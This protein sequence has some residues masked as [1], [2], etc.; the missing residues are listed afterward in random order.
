MRQPKRY[1]LLTK[2]KQALGLAA[3]PPPGND[4]LAL[5]LSGGGARGVYQA[6]V[7]SFIAEAFPDVR[8]KTLTGYSVGALN[9]VHLAASQAESFSE[10]VSELSALWSSISTDQVFEADSSLSTMWRLLI[11]R[12]SLNGG[13][14]D[15]DSPSIKGMVDTEPLREFLLSQIDVDNQGTITGIDTNISRGRLHALAVLT[16]NYTTGQTNAFA[17]GTD[18]SHWDR[19]MRRSIST[20]IGIEHIMASSALPLFFP[21]IKIGNQWHGDGGIRLTAPLAP[22]LHLGANRLLVVSTRARLSYEEASAA[23][24]VDYPSAGHILGILMNAVF[25]DMLDQDARLLTRINQLA[26]ELPKRKRQGLRRVEAVLIRPS[27]SLEKLSTVNHAES[28]LGFRLFMKVIGASGEESPGWMSML[29]FDPAYISRIKEVGYA[30]AKRRR[31]DL[32]ALFAG[33]EVPIE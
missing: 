17:Q 6:G 23:D 13:R 25:L 33:E 29:N 5:V 26:R 28:S 22:A 1:G 32:E 24:I 16:A 4:D 19:P 3:P 11:R 31:D 20:R 30:D 21:A 12:R 14:P 18:I 10:T 9:A 2:V 15:D 7:L 27:T 8:P